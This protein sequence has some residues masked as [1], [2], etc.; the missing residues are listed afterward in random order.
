MSFS[1]GN[2]ETT[3][4]G[5]F[6]QTKTV[7]DKNLPTGKNE[8]TLTLY[9]NRLIEQFQIQDLEEFIT[10]EEHSPDILKTAI[11]YY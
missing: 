4:K 8:L 1:K 6:Y 7:S 10:K 3:S 11:F 5:K 9:L 2:N